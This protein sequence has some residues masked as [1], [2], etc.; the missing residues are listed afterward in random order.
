[1]GRELLK[2]ILVVGLFVLIFGGGG[3]LAGEHKADPTTLIALISAFLGLVAGFASL[4]RVYYVGP[5]LSFLAGAVLYLQTN[6]LPLLLF[7]HA[8]AVLSY[9]WL[10][11][12]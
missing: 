4:K 7:S 1:M 9:A 12:A 11:Q 6:S 2:T 8:A 5:G 3:Y 10:K